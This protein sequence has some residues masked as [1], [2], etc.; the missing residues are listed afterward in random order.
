MNEFSCMIDMV[1]GALRPGRTPSAAPATPNAVAFRNCRRAS[2]DNEFASLDIATSLSP[3]LSIGKL[4][5]QTFFIDLSMRHSPTHAVGLLS[6]SVIT[7]AF[8]VDF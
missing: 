7:V 6:I 8:L 5:R 1:F 2:A 4:R 3:R